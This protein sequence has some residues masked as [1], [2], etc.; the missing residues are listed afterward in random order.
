VIL[1]R[2]THR[3]IQLQFEASRIN[4]ASI[5]LQVG[6]NFMA[7]CPSIREDCCF[8]VRCSSS[9]RSANFHLIP[10]PI[11]KG[12]QRERM[13]QWNQ[14]WRHSKSGTADTCPD[15][16]RIEQQSRMGLDLGGCDPN[17]MWCLKTIMAASKIPS[18]SLRTRKKRYCRET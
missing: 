9:T 8:G 5:L 12:Q 11:T 1:T 7:M 13:Q 14:S 18:I 6:F 17:S 15:I 2:E 3:I 4:R 10:L 16:E